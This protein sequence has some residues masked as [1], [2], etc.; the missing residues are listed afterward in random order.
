MT[1][2]DPIPKHVFEIT[3]TGRRNE[4]AGRV[5]VCFD[6]AFFFPPI[7]LAIFGITGMLLPPR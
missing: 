6:L 5:V 3:F 7:L 2:S 1:L 4:S